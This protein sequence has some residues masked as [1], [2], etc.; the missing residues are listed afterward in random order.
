M[1]AASA[2]VVASAPFSDSPY[3]SFSPRSHG[4]TPLPGLMPTRP[5]QA[6]GIRIEPIPSL[7]C[8]SGT[9]PAATAAA[10]PPDE[11]PGVRSRFHGLRV[12]P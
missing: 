2:T 10:E 5:V 8:A 7:P 11:P 1:S 9:M 6:A 3:Q 12:T 4:T